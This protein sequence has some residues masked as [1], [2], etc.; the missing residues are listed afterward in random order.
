V[1]LISLQKEDGLDQ[2]AA[3]PGR[4]AIL[5]LG[6]SLTDFQDTAAVMMSLDLVITS[7]TAAAHLAGGLGR[8]VWLAL[9]AVPHWTWLL[10]R[11][12]CPWYPSARLFRQT[13]RGDW[14]GVFQRIT[15][16]LRQRLKA[17]E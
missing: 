9:K 11:D 16:A 4:E 3:L 8:P 5:N 14:E 12:D 2:L 13:R 10:D 17:P 6:P 7:C 15:E 1:T